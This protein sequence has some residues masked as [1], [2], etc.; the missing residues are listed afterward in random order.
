MITTTSC[1]GLPGID[2]PG[3]GRGPRPRDLLHT[4]TLLLTGVTPGQSVTLRGHRAMWG[5]QPARTLAEL[6]VDADASALVG[7]GGAGFPFA[8]KLESLARA[9]VPLVIVNGSE[10]E[11]ASGK[12][13]ALLSHVP[14][15]VLDGA[16]AA[17]G[18]LGAR[19]I[20]VRVGQG[21]PDLAETLGAAIAQRG[22][23]VRIEVSVGPASFIA[24]EASAVIQSVAGGPA[25]PAEL[26]RPPRAAGGLPWRRGH[27]L[28]SNVETFARLAL[29]AR[30][31]RRTSCLASASG[32]VARPGVVE[33]N[34]TATMA[35]LAAAAGGVAG[36]P[37]IVIT[38]GW[39]GRWIPWDATSGATRLTRQ[40]VARAGG[41]WGAGA[42]VWLPEDVP[43]AVAL[44]SIAWELAAATAGQCG[45]CRHGLPEIA[46]LIEQAARTGEGRDA[47]E[48]VM[49]QVDGRGM[50]AHP[51]ATASALRSALEL[52]GR[53]P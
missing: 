4:G 44:A 35:D 1:G 50:C 41:R 52:I 7:A 16:C 23:D 28:L 47:I 15:L 31:I 38:G 26:G 51:S 49:A 27:V 9:R 11:S 20:V 25:L 39:Q 19:R 17:A 48:Q 34:D 3:T 37:T 42:F 32:A 13:A 12:D 14:H 45:P 43:P 36:R 46:G 8:R 10:G 18:A 24:G 5:G 53:G 6:V 22:E 2:V 21:R 30:G 29:A 33:L 40:A